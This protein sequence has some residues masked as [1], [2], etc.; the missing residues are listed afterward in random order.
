MCSGSTASLQEQSNLGSAR[1]LDITPKWTRRAMCF[2]CRITRFLP[3]SI[4]GARK[5]DALAASPRAAGP[6]IAFVLFHSGFIRCPFF[7]PQVQPQ[8]HSTACLL[9]CSWR[10]AGSSQRDESCLPPRSC[11]SRYR[12]YRAQRLSSHSLVDCC[13]VAGHNSSENVN[14]NLATITTEG[15]RIHLELNPL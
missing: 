8:S 5:P 1:R 4:R 13:H 10:T 15:K 9:P 2:L 11:A 3:R 7:Y 14:P 12:V 6:T